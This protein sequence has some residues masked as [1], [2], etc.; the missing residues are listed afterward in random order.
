MSTKHRGRRKAKKKERQ[1]CLHHEVQGSGG[2]STA[3][4]AN[5][6]TSAAHSQIPPSS[7]AQCRQVLKAADLITSPHP[8]IPHPFGSG[9]VMGPARPGLCLCETGIVVHWSMVLTE[10]SRGLNNMINAISIKPNRMWALCVLTIIT[11]TK[12]G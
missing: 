3:L 12:F 4:R 9:R 5:V 11:I 7:G 6:R 1:T 10:P 2:Q 8:A